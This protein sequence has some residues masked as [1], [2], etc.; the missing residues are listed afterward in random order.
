MYLRQQFDVFPQFKDAMFGPSKPLSTFNNGHG[1]NRR[2]IFMIIS[3]YHSLTKGA[4]R[5]RDPLRVL[6]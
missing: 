5:R 3:A 1:Y 2:F 6:G 4:N